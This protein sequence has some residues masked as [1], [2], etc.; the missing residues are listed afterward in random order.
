MGRLMAPKEM[1]LRAETDPIT[2]PRSSFVLILNS[3]GLEEGERKSRLHCS[4][5]LR[6]QTTCLWSWSLQQLWEPNPSL[7]HISPALSP[8]HY[9]HSGSRNVLMLF[10]QGCG[11]SNSTGNSQEPWVA[12]VGKRSWGKGPNYSEHEQPIMMLC[13]WE[14]LPRYQQRGAQSPNRRHFVLCAN[15]SG[16]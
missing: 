14:A 6:G 10:Q 4:K 5:M 15:T 11:F 16:A 7:V 1:E 3:R 2:Q 12:E 8:Q 9:P 13:L